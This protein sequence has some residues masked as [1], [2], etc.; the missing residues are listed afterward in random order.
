VL[1]VWVA[2]G[3]AGYGKGGSQPAANFTAKFSEQ[4]AALAKGAAAMPTVT[5]RPA[6]SDD[7]VFFDEEGFDWREWATGAPNCYPHP[8]GYPPPERIRA[9][10]IRAGFKLPC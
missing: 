3:F 6:R 8:C 10:L 2:D 7:R 5:P 9:A 1:E 4:A